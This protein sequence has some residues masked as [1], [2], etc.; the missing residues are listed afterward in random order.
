[1]L[2]SD[3]D[4]L[5]LLTIGFGGRRIRME[6]KKKGRKGRGRENVGS[7]PLYPGTG[8]SLCAKQAPAVETRAKDNH[9]S[10]CTRR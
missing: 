3:W 6:Q 7:L 2:V 5:R 8:P 1:M 4:P 9:N 10:S